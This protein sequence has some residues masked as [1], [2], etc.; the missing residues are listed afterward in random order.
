M[1]TG[2]HLRFLTMLIGSTCTFYSHSH[3]QCASTWCKASAGNGRSM[4]EQPAIG[5]DGTC[6]VSDWRG[7]CGVQDHLLATSPPATSPPAA[8]NLA[9]SL[10]SS[11]WQSNCQHRRRPAWHLFGLAIHTSRCT[12]RTQCHTA[13]FPHTHTTQETSH[14][15][16]LQCAHTNKHHKQTT[17]STHVNWKH[18]SLKHTHTSSHVLADVSCPASFFMFFGSYSGSSTNMAM[19]SLLL[20]ATS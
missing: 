20:R 7:N 4:R 12:C 8:S 11:S 14:V 2:K 18:T 16:T 5:G 9:A 13:D 15:L 3:R 17:K 6:V 19:A 1:P 10:I